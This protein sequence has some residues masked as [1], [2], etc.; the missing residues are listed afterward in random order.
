MN[1]ENTGKCLQVEL[2][3]PSTH[4]HDRFLPWLGS[5]TSMKKNDGL[6][7]L[8]RIQTSPLGEIMRSYQRFQH[9]RNMLSL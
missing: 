5:D 6:K 7:L 4:I 8:L 2:D 9:A 1:E 3:T